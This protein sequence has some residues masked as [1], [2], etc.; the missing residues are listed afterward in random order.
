MGDDCGSTGYIVSRL[1]YRVASDNIQALVNG[2]QKVLLGHCQDLRSCRD[3]HHVIHHVIH[4][5]R[6]SY[7]DAPPSEYRRKMI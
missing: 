7:Q 3:N 6:R 2:G 4:H 5:D 1:P